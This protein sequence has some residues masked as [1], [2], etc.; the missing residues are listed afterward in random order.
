MDM[1]A[2]VILPLPLAQEFTYRLPKECAHQVTIGSRVVVPFGRKKYYTGLVV[3]VYDRYEGTLDLK[4]IY[5][6]LDS[7]PIVLPYQISFWRWIASY[8]MCGIGDVLKAALPSGLKIESETWIELN[9][10][11][12]EEVRLSSEEHQLLDLLAVKPKQRVSQIESQWGST[13][14][15]KV[16]EQLIDKK[17]IHLREELQ[18]NYRPKRETY[19]ALSKLWQLEHQLES[20]CDELK[21]APKQQEMLMKYLEISEFFRMK[22]PGKVTR[23]EL[24]AATNSSTS[25]CKAL[26]DKGVFILQ[27]MEVGRLNEEDVEVEAFYDLN[28]FQQQAYNQILETLK[29]KD[30]CLLHG[31]TS[32]GKTEIYIHLIQK[33]L[34]EGK[35]ILYLLPEIALT[36]QITRRL[37]RVFGNQLGVYHSKC[38]DTERVEIWKKQLST[39]PYQVILGVRSSIFL[40]FQNLGLIIIDEEHET[41]YKQQEPAPR[42]HARNSALFLGTMLKAKTILGTATPAVETWYNASIGKYGLVKLN[43]RYKEIQ[44]PEV[45]PVDIQELHRKKRMIGQF[46]PILLNEIEEALQ[47]KEQ[48]IL[49]QNRRGFAPMLECKTCGWVPKCEHCD[50]SLTY[51]KGLRQLTCHYCGSVYPIPFQC[52]AC[53]EKDLRYKGFGTEKVEDEVRQLF[54]EVPVARMDLDTTRNRNAYEQILADFEQGKTQILIGT[55]MVS[56]GLDFD[57]VRVVGILNADTML[58]YPDFR[59]YERAF[60]L[61]AQVSGRAGRKWKRGRV[62]LQTRNIE[63]PIINQV[64]LNDYDGMVKDQ[65]NERKLFHYPPFHRLIYIY[66]RHQNESL[67]RK[68]AQYFANELYHV[69]GSRVLGPDNPPVGRVQRFY[70]QKIIVKI[71]ADSSIKQAMTLLH[72]I[73]KSLS[74]DIQFRSIR[75]HYDVDPM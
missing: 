26:V 25:V 50:V 49:F 56:K 18:N 39:N 62:I 13:Q 3:K 44:L 41:T 28:S 43:E 74:K 68:M 46:S 1:Y 32:S 38:S 72:Q 58:N 69:F 71:E 33:A 63:H 7:H 30:T 31:V 75:I 60:Q 53:E 11:F 9:E 73:E 67:V 10:D 52:P 55:Q 15:F 57:H 19:V 23:R 61:M 5:Q 35:Q 4:P 8:Y 20:L 12:K 29:N 6:V 14:L 51:H 17:A 54:P 59:S 48:V 22:E 27:E 65:L 2:D 37:H 36:T 16:L 42:Y 70:I 24:I 64:I 47:N 34:D 21:R 40:P 66:L 45:I